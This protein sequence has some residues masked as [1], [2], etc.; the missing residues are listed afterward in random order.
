[1][2]SDFDCALGVSHGM[3]AA[4]CGQSGLTGVCT[5]AQRL[6]YPSKDW[7]LGA[8]PLTALMALGDGVSFD[9]LENGGFIIRLNSRDHLT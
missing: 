1:M 5:T 6:C 3:L 2:I 4:A 7:Q 9:F 8:V